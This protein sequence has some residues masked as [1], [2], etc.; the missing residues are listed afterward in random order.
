MVVQVKPVNVREVNVR[1]YIS[2]TDALRQLMLSEDGAHI[3][4]ISPKGYTLR[5]GVDYCSV[6]L[7][8]EDGTDY[9]VQAYGKEAIELHDEATGGDLIE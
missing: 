2:G 7:K 6:G 5:N 8:S 9:S 3:V 1:T 4:R